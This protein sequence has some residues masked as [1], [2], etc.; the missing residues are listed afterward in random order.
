VC[1]IRPRPQIRHRPALVRSTA[2][3]RL[4]EA[5]VHTS[6][7]APR[8][9]LQSHALSVLDD[10]IVLAATVSATVL[11]EVVSPS[12]L[13][14]PRPHTNVAVQIRGTPSQMPPIPRWPEVKKDMWSKV[15]DV[16]IYACY[17]MYQRIN[18]GD[19]R[20]WLCKRN[21]HDLTLTC[22]EVLAP[23]AF[24]SGNASKSSG[25]NCM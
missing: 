17:A 5:A 16:R 13:T 9:A 14:S 3:S 11:Q 6:P 7:L 12:V 25:I 15:K 19:F 18:F 21:F 8:P 24:P 22:V 20:T 23:S 1:V 2:W 4:C 10:A